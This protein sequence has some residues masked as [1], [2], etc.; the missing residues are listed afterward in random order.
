MNAY[1]G[2]AL[3]Y[4]KK[5]NNTSSMATAMM[6]N[7]RIG[8]MIISFDYTTKLANCHEYV[9][10]WD[11]FSFEMNQNQDDFILFLKTKARIARLSLQ[12]KIKK[13]FST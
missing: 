13:W 10:S 7:N 2:G 1:D 3:T 8:F 6:V 12:K 11:A 4:D 9:K 5:R